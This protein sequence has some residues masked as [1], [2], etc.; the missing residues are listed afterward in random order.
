MVLLPS[1]CLARWTAVDSH[2]RL[3]AAMQVVLAGALVL[4]FLPETIFDLRPGR[5]WAQLMETT[6]WVRQLWRTAFAAGAAG[7]CGSDG[8]RRTRRGNANPVRPAEEAGA[9]R[10]LSI[11]R[12]PNA[13]ELFPGHGAVGDV[14]AEWVDGCGGR[15]VHGL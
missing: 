9:E 12:E 14:V 7:G 13:T 4:L 11:C 3:R 6:G 15:H 1:L 10:D 2:L 8:V 5:G